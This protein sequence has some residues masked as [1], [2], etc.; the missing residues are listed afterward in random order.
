MCQKNDKRRST[1]RRKIIK[2]NSKTKFTGVTF[3][4]VP[5]LWLESEIDVVYI[6]EDMK[7]SSIYV[8]G[9]SKHNRCVVDCHLELLFT[10]HL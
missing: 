3:E 6:V 2:K 9:L 1:K 4:G 7:H 5:T 10:N 8:N